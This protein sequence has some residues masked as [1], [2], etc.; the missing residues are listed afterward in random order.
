VRRGRLVFEA[1][2]PL[3]GR[4]R[5]VDAGAERLLVVGGAVLSVYPLDGDWARVRREYWWIA[6]AMVTLPAR[7]SALFVGLGGGT[8]LH[9]LHQRVHPRRLTV[10]ERDPTIIRVA[11]RCFAL[12]AIPNLE[13][14]CGDAAG[15]VPTLARTRRRFDFIMEDATYG[16]SVERSVELARG[17]AR[18]VSARGV[19]VVNHHRHGHARQA[20]AALRPLFA[21]VR[22][23]R[24]RR[25]AENVLVCGTGPRTRGAPGTPQAPHRSGGPGAAG[26]PLDTRAAPRP[27]NGRGSA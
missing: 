10:I 16:D 8:Q 14:L 3:S 13:V 7:S 12:D 5:V 11:A 24:V 23:R 18:L 20:A 1:R 27:R 9:L 2:S 22:L 17:L 4:I 26:T 25:E 21:E 6:L 15:I 19:L